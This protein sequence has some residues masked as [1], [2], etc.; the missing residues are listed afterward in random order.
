MRRAIAAILLPLLGSAALAQ[1]PE[2]VER[3]SSPR[4]FEAKGAV[5]VNAVGANLS[6]VAVGQDNTAKNSAGALKENVKI[7]GNTTI[8]AVSKNATAVAVGKGNAATND[9]GA[10]GNK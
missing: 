3:S 1:L 4:G 10:I 6:S 2:G 7:Q 9:V 8:N 5:N